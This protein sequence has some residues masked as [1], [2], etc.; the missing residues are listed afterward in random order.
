M[1]SGIGICDSVQVLD[2]REVL[3]EVLLLLLN[4]LSVAAHVIES[5]LND[6]RE[7]PAAIVAEVRALLRVVQRRRHGLLLNILCDP[8]LT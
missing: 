7:E 8:E 3:H 4:L 5:A 1:F 2:W 6:T